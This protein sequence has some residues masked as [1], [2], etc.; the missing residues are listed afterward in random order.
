MT[1]S[2]TQRFLTEG[3]VIVVSI[4]LAFGID[5]SWDSYRADKEEQA[6]LRDLHRDFSQSVAALRDLSIPLMHAVE[7]ATAELA[8]HSSGLQEPFPSNT[9]LLGDWE[10]WTSDY[11]LRITESWVSEEN[12]RT[13]VQDSLLGISISGPIQFEPRLPT[14]DA[15]LAGQGLTSLRSRELRAAL[16]GFPAR[17]AVLREMEDAV[18]R[19]L[20]DSYRP[21]VWKAA[22]ATLAEFTNLGWWITDQT[23]RPQVLDVHTVEIDVSRELVNVMAHRI[24][25]ANGVGLIAEEIASEMDE[26]LRLIEEQLRG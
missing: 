13:E 21:L 6:V 10:A 11:L 15:L 17:L 9:L 18:T 14:L 12:R 22:N 3:T 4:L 7:S 20:L 25:Q 5:A 24:G 8:W 19:S 16:A 2:S 23:Q 1:K 26:I